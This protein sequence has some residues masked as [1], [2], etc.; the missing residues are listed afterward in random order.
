MAAALGA[1]NGYG[2]F[3]AGTTTLYGDSEANLCTENLK[4]NANIGKTNTG[5]IYVNGSYEASGSN[6]R[7][8]NLILNTATFAERGGQWFVNV[9]GEGQGGQY[10]GT[11]GQ[12]GKI[13]RGS[14]DLAGAFTQI[15]SN[16]ETLF[17][18]GEELCPTVRESTT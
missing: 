11:T 17:S 14:F 2:I 12:V 5:T 7:C 10:V 18:A 6:I 9:D 8:A 1:A 3:V 4:Y 13:E 16:A 15:R